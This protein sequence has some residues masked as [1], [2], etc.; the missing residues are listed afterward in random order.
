MANLKS[1]L[2]R[3]LK[4]LLMRRFP[5]PATIQL[6]DNDGI[7][8]VIT[9]GEFQGVDVLDRQNI[10]GDT[11]EPHLTPE[12]NRRVQV[13]VGVTPEEETAYSAGVE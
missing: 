4:K 5:P 13:I 2:T 8:G 1:P 3:K 9:S 11:I 10:I 7:I 12:E 6:E